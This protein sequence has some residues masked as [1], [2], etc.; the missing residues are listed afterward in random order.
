MVNAS[1]SRIRIP[2]AY[3]L[4]KCT[5]FPVVSRNTGRWSIRYNWLERVSFVKRDYLVLIPPFNREK[6][7][8]EA[9]ATKR[10]VHG[11]YQCY[12]T[13]CHIPRKV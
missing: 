6:M 1:D 10:S 13:H 11:R 12:E 7:K 5:Y 8:N 9:I 3:L 4:D 2:I